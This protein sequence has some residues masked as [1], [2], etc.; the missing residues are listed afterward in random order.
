MK[1]EINRDRSEG[2]TGSNVC[3]DL[4]NFDLPAPL[5][6]KLLSD[7]CRLVPLL[8]FLLRLRL[9]ISNPGIVVPVSNPCPFQS[10]I[11]RSRF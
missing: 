3:S 8:Q 10:R 9:K 6:L 2:S 7:L 4:G 5:V 11:C 1:P